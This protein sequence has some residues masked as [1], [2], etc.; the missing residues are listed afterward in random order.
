MLARAAFAEMSANVATV[1]ANA[2][3]P[4]PGW[5]YMVVCGDGPH[6]AVVND[7][8]VPQR[9]S[10]FSWWPLYGD[11]STGFTWTALFP[12]DIGGAPD[13]RVGAME[14]GGFGFKR[15]TIVT[16]VLMGLLAR[17]MIAPEGF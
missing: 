12:I 9:I 8:G 5:V 13:A 17:G 14:S 4:I 1:A 16:S 10:E 6:L 3:D 11:V 15:E 7:Q 2:G